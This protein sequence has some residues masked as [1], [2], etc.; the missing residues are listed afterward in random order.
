MQGWQLVDQAS[1][2]TIFP[3]WA[4]TSFCVWS[5]LAISSETFTFS[6]SP[7]SFAA[8]FFRA[9]FSSAELCTGAAQNVTEIRTANMRRIAGLITGE[10]RSVCM[11][12][13]HERRE[14]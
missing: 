14:K 13:H 3:L 4:A 10:L 11:V 7:G 8:P 6:F 1:R 12:K 2:T 5:Q 9:G